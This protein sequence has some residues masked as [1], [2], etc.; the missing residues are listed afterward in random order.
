MM[1]EKVS[2]LDPV[3]VP[4]V[5]AEPELLS[6]LGLVL[7]R[8]ALAEPDVPTGALL[9][10]LSHAVLGLV[11]GGAPGSLAR[12]VPGGGSLSAPVPIQT[13]QPVYQRNVRA[14]ETQGR[15]LPR[16]LR[17]WERLLSRD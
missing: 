1:P 17:L 16:R 12:V 11:E 6:I 15:R 5:L 14:S 9:A 8:E 10:V 3:V 7:L 13:L 4:R 2:L